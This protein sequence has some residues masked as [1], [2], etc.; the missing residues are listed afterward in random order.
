MAYDLAIVGGGL[1]GAALAIVMAR[2]GARVLILER[3]LHFRDRVRGEGFFPWGCAE[4]E[5]LG[6]LN[7]IRTA[8][9]RDVPRWTFHP[10][11]DQQVVRDLPT[12]SPSGMGMLNFHHEKLQEALIELAAVSGAEVRRGV[13]VTGVMPGVRPQVTFRI[14]GA[15][16]AVAARLIVGADGRYSRVRAWAGFAAQR[17][18]EFVVTASTL[19]ERVEAEDGSIHVVANSGQGRAMLVYPLGEGMFRSYMIHRS[20]ETGPRFSGERAA[21]AFLAACRAIGGPAGWYDRAIH[22]GGLLASF[23]GAPSWVDHPA[24][25]GVVLVGDAAGAS[26]PAFGSGLSLALRDVRVLRDVLLRHEDW[27]RAADLYAAQHDAYFAALKRI[28][29]W[30]TALSYTPGPEADAVRARSQAGLRA[31]PSRMP[32]IQGWG[33]DAPSDDMARRRLFGL[34]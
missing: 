28:T 29:D 24:R 3:E 15:D 21:A 13:E 2:A 4:A 19:H 14:G 10:A 33:P 6:L 26:D 18:P 25:D 11:P 8:C 7:E 12:T 27:N 5:R 34:D 16:N 30:R 9:G 23:E 31:D 1:T 20:S 17:D 22:A 32:D